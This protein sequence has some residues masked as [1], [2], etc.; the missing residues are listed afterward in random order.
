MMVIVLTGGI[1]SGKSVAAEYFGAR[2]ASVISL[3]EIA[4]RLIAAGS[5]VLASVAAEFGDQILDADGSLN[6]PALAEVC[7]A[8]QA[9]AERLD[10]L[11]HPSVARETS[12]QLTALS[13]RSLPPEVVVVEVPLLAEA[14]E[15]T[16]L[17]DSVLAITAPQEVRIARAVARGLDRADVERRVHVQAPDSARTALADVVIENDGTLVE[18]V[19]ALGRFW[20]DNVGSGALDG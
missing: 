4:H 11:V 8:D 17:A 15:F 18:Y 13:R 16:K 14:P 3:D 10:A 9:A 6:R 20:D 5:P 7:F 12:A 1:G 2:G 19:A